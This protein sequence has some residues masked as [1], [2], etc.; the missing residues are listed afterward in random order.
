LYVV[1]TTAELFYNV[2][3]HRYRVCV[4]TS[5]IFAFLSPYLC[6]PDQSFPIAFH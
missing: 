3:Y 2:R 1:G 6:L 5:H 4:Q